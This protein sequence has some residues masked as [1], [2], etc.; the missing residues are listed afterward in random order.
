MHID[1]IVSYVWGYII[2][3]VTDSILVKFLYGIIAG[4]FVTMYGS[5]KEI[6]NLMLILYAADFF[7]GVTVALQKRSFESRKFF[8][9]AVK[10]AVYGLLLYVA[11]AVDS[12]IFTGEMIL[13]IMLSFIILTDASSII[14]NLHQLGFEVPYSLVKYLG[15]A[16]DRLDDKLAKMLE[17][18]TE[19]APKD[20]V[21]KKEEK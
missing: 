15:V 21:S 1:G 5:H 17:V 11:R 8:R 4:I 10:L 9:G 19:E 13:S 3:T 2:H 7:L 20:T 14:E 6:I 18:E 16:R 12:A